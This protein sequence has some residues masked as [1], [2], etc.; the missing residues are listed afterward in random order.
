MREDY[1]FNKEKIGKKF[2]EKW[3]IESSLKLEE[4]YLMIPPDMSYEVSLKINLA[5]PF[6]KISVWNYPKRSINVEF[7]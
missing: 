1:S 3:R 4:N 5:A 6:V 7:K 2:V